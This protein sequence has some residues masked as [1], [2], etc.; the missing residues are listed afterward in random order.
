VTCQQVTFE[1]LR[2]AAN[3]DLT[4]ALKQELQIAMNFMYS[5]DFYEARPLLPIS[6]SGSPGNEC[7]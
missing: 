1:A 6:I 2:R 4:Q 3:L 5:H 7:L